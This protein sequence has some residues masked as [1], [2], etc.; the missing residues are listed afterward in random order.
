MTLNV[1]RIYDEREAS[2][3]YRVLID[4]L[5]PRGVSKE[6]A[7]LDLWLKDIA[8][9]PGLRTWFGHRQENFA[10]FGGRY[11]EELLNNPAVAELQKIISEHKDVTLLY[12]AHDPVVNHA[13]VLLEYLN[14]SK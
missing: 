10:E 5:W 1:K 4:G 12:A 2:D 6:R 7:Q 8:P 9:S 13:Q 3:G 11:N 14:R